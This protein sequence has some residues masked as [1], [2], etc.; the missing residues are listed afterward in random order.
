MNYYNVINGYK[1]IFLKKDLNDHLTLPEEFK[2]GTTFEELYS[3]YLMDFELKK[4]IFPHLL[5]FEKL[6]KTACAYYFSEKYTEPY[7]FLQMKNL[8]L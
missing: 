7:S 4:V 6:L 3:L 5:R 2:Q 1:N 8:S